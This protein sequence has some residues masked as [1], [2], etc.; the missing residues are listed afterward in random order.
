MHFNFSEIDRTIRLLSATAAPRPIAWVSTMDGAGRIN[1]A[2]FSFFN[3]FGED[4]ATVGFS[5]LQRSPDDPKETG[6]NIAR[7]GE[8]VVMR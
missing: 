6:R 2:P 3:A 4:P 8:F 7:S 5:I 1:A